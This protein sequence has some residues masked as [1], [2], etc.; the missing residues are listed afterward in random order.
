MDVAD[1]TVTF[2]HTEPPTVTVELFTK[3]VPVIVMVVPPAV[4]PVTGLTDETVGVEATEKV[5]DLAI[6][7]RAPSALLKTKLTVYEPTCVGVPTIV[8]GR[9]QPVL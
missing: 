4:L 3:F 8:A 5:T 9:T 7:P 6:F 2:V 1:T